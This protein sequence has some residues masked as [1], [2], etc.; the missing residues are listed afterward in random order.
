MYVDLYAICVWNWNWWLTQDHFLIKHWSQRTHR[1]SASVVG[2]EE[3]SLGLV[4]QPLQHGEVRDTNL[5]WVKPVIKI[6]VNE[7]GNYTKEFV[8]PRDVFTSSHRPWRAR[9]WQL[10]VQLSRPLTTDVN[11]D[12]RIDTLTPTRHS[13]NLANNE[14]M[15]AK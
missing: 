11:V 1:C 4:G 10:I 6:Y 14:L 2:P 12:N 13:M 9:G 8:S 15:V 3:Y 5:A 7:V